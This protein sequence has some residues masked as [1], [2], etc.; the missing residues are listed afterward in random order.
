[1]STTL[2][3]PTLSQPE[4]FGDHRE[5]RAGRFAHAQR[6]CSRLTPHA[7]DQIPAHRRARVFHQAFDD[8]RTDRARRLESERRRV[9][10]QRQIVVDRLGDGRD[11]DAALGE[12]GDTGRAVRRVV[13]ADAH[14]IADSQEGQRLDAALE[15]LGVFGRIRARGA[16]DGAAAEV[17]ARNVVDCQLVHVRGVAA[18]DVRVAVVEADHAQAVVDRFDRRRGDDPVDAGRGAAPDEYCERW[19][20]HRVLR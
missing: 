13:A 12:L 17:D 10:G 16:Q 11:A 5:G 8:A 6:Q 20:I 7:D 2:E 18:R 14:E 19:L 4:L 15:R 9:V 1:M 3:R